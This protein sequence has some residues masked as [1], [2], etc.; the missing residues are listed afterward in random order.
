MIDRH[1]LKGVRIRGYL[2]PAAGW[3][4]IARCHIGLALL[5]PI[6]NYYDSYPTKMFEYMAMGLPVIVSD[7]PLYRSIVE[8][9]N[10]GICV[11]PDSPEEIADAVQRLLD[12]PEQAKEMGMRGRA[13]TQKKHNWENE[14]GKLLEF[15]LSLLET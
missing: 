3:R 6:P 13:A 15:Y 2:L 14:Q 7:F 8:K 1:E 12:N 9:E 5:Q 4:I 11:D 10:C